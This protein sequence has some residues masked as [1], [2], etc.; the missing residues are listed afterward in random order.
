MKKSLFCSS[1]TICDYVP[2]ATF[3]D[4]IPGSND[5]IVEYELAVPRI[6]C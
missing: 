2:I 5:R 3:H 1:M 4:D 6:H